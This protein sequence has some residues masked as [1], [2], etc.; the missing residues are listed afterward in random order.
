MWCVVRLVYAGFK[1]SNVRGDFDNFVSP[2]A[3]GRPLCTY[4]CNRIAYKKHHSLSILLKPIFQFDVPP[5][6]PRANVCLG[7]NFLLQI[8]CERAT[9]D[10]G[11]EPRPAGREKWRKGLSHVFAWAK[12]L[13]SG[14]P[15]KL[16]FVH[17]VVGWLTP[18]MA[19][20]DLC[21][22]FCERGGERSPVRGG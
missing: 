16:F 20:V 7:R 19:G 14:V 11:R 18:K 3:P 10:R 9:A 8:C 21:K 22:P 13:T 6:V 5:S 4:R 2:C 15:K 12:T 1:Q 17:A